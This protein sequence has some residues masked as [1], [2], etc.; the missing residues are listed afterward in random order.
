MAMRAGLALWTAAALVAASPAFAQ[1]AHD[2]HGAGARE[3][4]AHGQDRTLPQQP[5]QDAFGAIAE[6]VRIL[7]ADPDTD[8]SR[9]DIGALHRHLTDMQAL[10]TQAEIEEEPVP[11]GLRMR[12]ARTGP[13]GDAAGRMVPAHAPILAADAGWD[14]A[15]EA[16]EAE[17]V[18]TVRAPSESGAVRIRALGF[19]GLMATGA[20]HRRHHLAIA[21]GEAMH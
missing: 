8:W 1:T 10:F 16:G 19:Y 4:A 17:I 21:R 13:G 20:H 2:R 11:G 6:I 5:G 14:S 12:I 15:V 3:H 9:V 18:W 7:N